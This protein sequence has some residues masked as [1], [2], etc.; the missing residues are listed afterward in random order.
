MTSSVEKT[1][2]DFFS[3]FGIP[4]YAIGT[5]P[6]NA[7]L[8]YITYTPID[9]D[10]NTPASLTATVWYKGTE[11]KPLF[12]KVDEIKA[13]VGEGLSLKIS[14]G[15]YVYLYKDSPFAQ[16]QSTDNDNVKAMYLLF[17]MHSLTD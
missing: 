13:K 1:L 6:D 5:V 11:L 17:G 4:A 9:T 16:F 15:G 14:T 8:P 3:G 12:D 7:E 2:Y 10:W